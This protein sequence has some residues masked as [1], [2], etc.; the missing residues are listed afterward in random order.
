MKRRQRGFLGGAA[1]L[2][3][4]AAIALIALPA[5]GTAPPGSAFFAKLDGEH[6]VPHA[7]PDGYGTF[8][9]G[10]NG[11]K[12]CFGL[13]VFKIATP[14]AAHIHQGAVGVNGPIKVTLNVPS[15]GAAGASAKCTTLSTTLANAI[16]ANPGHYYVNVHNG[17]F[18]NGAMRGQLFQ[19]TPSQD[20]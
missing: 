18:P 17:A 13:Q 10:F 15:A 20:K 19:A 6:E 4:L 12:L 5:S 11:T 9:A 1:C 2:T 14:T 16:K 3:V 8:S 7:D